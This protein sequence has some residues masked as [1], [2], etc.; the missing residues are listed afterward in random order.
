MLQNFSFVSL[1]ISKFRRENY[2]ARGLRDFRNFSWKKNSGFTLLEMV[3]SIGI[4]TTLVI[5]SMGIMI[6]ITRAQS[7]A[8]ALQAIQDN[9][10][11]SMELLVKELHTGANYRLVT[12]GQCG[13]IGNAM[14]FT[15]LNQGVQE[16]FYY[17]ADTNGDA[18]GDILMRV[19]MGTGESLDCARA[20]PLT[21][22]EIVVDTLTFDIHG[23]TSGPEDGQ[24]WVTISM[25]VYSKEARYGKETKMNLQTTV[26]SRIRDL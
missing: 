20:E 9:I 14:Q 8:A 4:F 11:F 1:K 12:N 15:S 25:G 22:E 17:L 18:I 13:S 5:A 2:Y 6:A 16:R 21:A 10:R 3:V 23:Q 24:P 19:A 7:K 26:V